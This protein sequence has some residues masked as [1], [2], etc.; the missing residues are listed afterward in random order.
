MAHDLQ[1]DDGGYYGYLSQ[2]VRDALS[3]TQAVAQHLHSSVVY[4]PSGDIGMHSLTVLS[5]L[6][7]EGELVAHGGKLLIDPNKMPVYADN[8][9]AISAG[10]E[11]GH[12]YRTDTGDLKIV[13]L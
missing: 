13:I 10:L 6:L 12:V 1:H 8:A 11:V 4:N 9:A 5:K 3:E 2:D 7:V